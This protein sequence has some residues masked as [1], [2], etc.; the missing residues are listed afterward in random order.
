M[1]NYKM[2]T[3]YICFEAV[4]ILASTHSDTNIGEKILSIIWL[5]YYRVLQYITI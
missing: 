3:Q 2:Y 4:V 5:Y 1:I